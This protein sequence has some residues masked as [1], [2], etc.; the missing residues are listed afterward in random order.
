M[1][2]VIIRIIGFNDTKIFSEAFR[3]KNCHFNLVGCKFEF[4]L[5]ILRLPNVKEKVSPF[6]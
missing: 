6:R 2:T 4:N 3:N 5:C 1:K